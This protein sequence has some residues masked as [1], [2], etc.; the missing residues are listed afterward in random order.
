MNEMSLKA[1]IRNLAKEN[2]IPAQLV[3]QQFFVERFLLRLSRTE[4]KDKFVLK[5]GTLTASIVGLSNRATMDMDTIIKGIPLTPDA[6]KDAIIEICSV[7]AD[8][9]I[10][11]E[12]VRI[13]PIRADDV[14]GGYRVMIEV[15]FEKVVAP[16]SMDISTGDILTP[17]AVQ[18]EF[19]TMFDDKEFCL[20]SYNIETILAEKVETIL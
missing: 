20:W 9:G 17:G 7:D 18:R 10:N 15:N 12:Y 19:E 3:M 14:Y 8:D 11:F 13:E 5:G 4:Y 1:R 6:I 16:T 2:G